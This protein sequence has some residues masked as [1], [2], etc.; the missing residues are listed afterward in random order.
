[1]HELLDGGIVL[2][3][4]RGGVPCPLW[5]EITGC[6]MQGSVG[7]GPALDAEGL[8]KVR[9]AARLLAVS[10]RFLQSLT[11]SGVVPS[12][13]LGKRGVRYLKQ[14]ILEVIDAHRSRA[15]VHA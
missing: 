10:E 7:M 3:V 1:M 12:V 9:D 5:P 14:D 8:L 4:R 11:R 2:G 6:V 13:R 15:E